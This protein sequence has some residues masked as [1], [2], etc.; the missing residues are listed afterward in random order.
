MRLHPQRAHSF[1]HQRKF[2]Q[3]LFRDWT[4]SEGTRPSKKG[5]TAARRVVLHQRI[6][7]A[8]LPTNQGVVGSNPAGRAK[9]LQGV[10]NVYDPLSRSG[11]FRPDLN[12]QARWKPASGAHFAVHARAA[13]V[14][15]IAKQV[16]DAH[17]QHERER[18][19]CSWRLG[20][21]CYFCR[22]YR[23][24]SNSSI[25]LPSGSS[26]W[27]CLPPGPTSISFRKR[28]PAFFSASIRVGK[29]LTRSTIRFHPP[30]SCL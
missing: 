12:T 3:G 17:R 28:N 9:F 26:S 21:H 11:D 8:G 15:H 23:A 25:G 1:A 2:A 24:S 13:L 7:P 30:G 18:R 19:R 14:G 5:G 4:V 29:S 20:A 16:D 22:S 6:A 27:I 10:S